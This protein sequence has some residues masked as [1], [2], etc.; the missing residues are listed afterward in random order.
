MLASMY[1]A[2]CSR[3]DCSILVYTYK[4]ILQVEVVRHWRPAV[5]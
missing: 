5:N 2:D 4:L 3:K 1:A